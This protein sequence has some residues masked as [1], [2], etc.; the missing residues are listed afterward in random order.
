MA[1]VPTKLECP[2]AA[3]DPGASISCHLR[4]FNGAE[5]VDELRVEFDGPLAPYATGTPLAL[6]LLP[7]TEGLFS[8]VIELPTDARVESGE[9]QL[10]IKAMSGL[11]EVEPALEE[12][13]VDVGCRTS[14]TLTVI[15][16]PGPGVDAAEVYEARVDSTSN[17][18]L[19]LLVEAEA[20]IGAVA[21]PSELDVAPFGRA[22]SIVTLD[23]TAGD[24][25]PV[26][27]VVRATGNGL[28][29]SDEVTCVWNRPAP[30][31]PDPVAPDPPPPP[32]PSRPSPE[33][34]LAPDPPRARPPSPAGCLRGVLRL[35]V[36]LIFLVGLAVVALVAW[37]VFQNRF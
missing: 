16:R 25:E 34:T 15:P 19:R 12:L 20:R 18:R 26:V 30:P 29:L 21:E 3:V 7:E 8:I 23:Q 14:A 33:P 22:H 5:K 28:V 9:Q 1:R 35:V 37:L 24:E 17:H 31:A 32:R 13:S 2:V 6:P 36:V 4:V 27:L 10:L 11:P